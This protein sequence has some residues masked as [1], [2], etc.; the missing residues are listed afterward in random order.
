MKKLAV[1]MKDKWNKYWSKI[2]FKLLIS[3]IGMLV[4]VGLLYCAGLRITY[5]PELKNDW[6][7]ISAYAAWFSV[8]VSIVGVGASFAAV[9]YAI[10]VP[11][12]IAEKQNNIAL[13]EKRYEILCLY[14]SCRTFANILK[15]IGESE[16]LTDIKLLF[17][18]VFCDVNAAEKYDKSNFI[19]IENEKMREKMMQSCYL[20]EK[21]ISPYIELAASL[22]HTIVDDAVRMKDEIEEE[23]YRSLVQALIKL[24]CD[25]KY[26]TICKKMEEKL[27][28]R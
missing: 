19:R 21:D 7:S 26:D 17:L 11:K 28:L 4:V 18:I 13:F 1:N 8:V 12:Q 9:W 10:Q 2:W 22:V 5:A 27:T 20:F 25:D 15:D 3:A 6:D 23:L 24:M 14:K 16:D